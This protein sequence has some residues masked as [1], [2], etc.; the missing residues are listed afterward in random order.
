MQNQNFIQTEVKLIEKRDGNKS[1]SS[2][3]KNA[4]KN[5]DKKSKEKVSEG[6]EAME[7]D[8]SY[9]DD[10]HKAVLAALVLSPSII[11]GGSRATNKPSSSAPSSSTGPGSSCG[12][13]VRVPS[14]L[15]IGLGGGAMPMCMQRYL[16]GM[17]LATCEMDA[18]MHSIAVKF[19][20]FRLVLCCLLFDTMLRCLYSLESV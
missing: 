8:Y 13:R 20:A 5:K 16:P 10:H 19:F 14:G 12:A 7:F 6:A 4:K 17:R 1:K 11:Q 15:I 18:D 9:L 2:G 3:G